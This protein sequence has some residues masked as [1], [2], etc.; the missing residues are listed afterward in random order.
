MAVRPSC[1]ISPLVTVLIRWVSWLEV[2]ITRLVTVEC[3][4]KLTEMTLLVPLL[5]SE[6]RMWVSALLS[7]LVVA[8]A[9]ADVDGMAADRGSFLANVLYDFGVGPLLIQY[10]RCCP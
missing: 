9:G 4:C 8:V 3:L 7:A 1:L 5:L 2:T 10:V 6:V